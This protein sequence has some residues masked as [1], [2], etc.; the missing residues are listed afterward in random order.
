MEIVSVTS[1]KVTVSEPAPPTIV[2]L[3]SCGDPKEI[4]SLSSPPS[5]SSGDTMSE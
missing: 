1:Y 2:T 5:I 3:P 4:W